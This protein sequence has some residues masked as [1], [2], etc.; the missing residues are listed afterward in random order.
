V[1]NEALGIAATKLLNLLNKYLL[2]VTFQDGKN[3]VI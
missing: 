3:C 1:S 2:M